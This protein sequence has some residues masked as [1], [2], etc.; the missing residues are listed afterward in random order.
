MKPKVHLFQELCE[1]KAQLFG[2]PELFWT[3]MDESF[4]G[5]LALAAKRRGGR[6]AAA[7]VPDRL[8]S[9]YRAM[10]G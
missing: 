10:R 5:F 2:S 4:C 3:Y 6:V 9:R 7:A 1:Y 8:L